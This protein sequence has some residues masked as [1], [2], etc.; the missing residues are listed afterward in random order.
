LKVIIAVSD[1]SIAAEMADILKNNFYEVE[2]IC[3]DTTEVVNYTEALR[4][5]LVIMDIDLPGEFS[6]C[7]VTGYFNNV[8]GIPVVYLT[9]YS[10]EEK[11]EEAIRTE[12]Y[13]FPSK[14]KKEEHVYINLE[15]A[16]KKY[17]DSFILL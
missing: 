10:G 16:Y 1:K 7:E 4:P 9:I 5:D 6:S 12:P 8:F 2:H 13:G 17:T 3:S 14:H 15:M 11:K